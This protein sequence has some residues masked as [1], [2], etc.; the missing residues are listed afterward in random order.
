MFVS[1]MVFYS[2]CVLFSNECSVAI[3]VVVE[4]LQSQQWK[5]ITVLRSRVLSS[6]DVS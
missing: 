5:V 3:A 2:F 1:Y 6:G 4:K